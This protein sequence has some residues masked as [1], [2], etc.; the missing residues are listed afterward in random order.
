MTPA[1][2]KLEDLAIE[3]LSELCK[4][5]YEETKWALEKALDKAIRFGRLLC[6]AKS[7]IPHGGWIA[8]VTET[9]DDQVSLRNIQR[10]MQVAESNTTTPSLLEGAKN[11]DDALVRIQVKKP[12]VEVIDTVEPAQELDS[13]SDV[14]TV[15][16][17]DQ[18]KPK[19]AA[20]EPAMAKEILAGK[21]KPAAQP[22]TEAEKKSPSVIEIERSLYRMSKDKKRRPQLKLIA[23]AAMNWMTPKDRVDFLASTLFYLEK[24]E[25]EDVLHECEK[26]QEAELESDIE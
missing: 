9:F 26:M 4:E 24:Q 22:E 11:L 15:T 1:T 8:W 18:S 10:Y 12:V 14:E 6:I 19:P 3:P 2:L 20:E 17:P 7:K 16:Q 23:G 21:D 5:A 25:R 13:G